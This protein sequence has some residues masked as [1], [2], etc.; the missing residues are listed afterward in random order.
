MPAYLLIGPSGVGKSSALRSVEARSKIPVYSLDEFIKGQSGSDSISSHL[1]IVGPKS[2][3]EESIQG[4]EYIESLYNQN[5]IIDVGAGSIDFGPGHEW[6]LSRNTICL[7]GDPQIIYERGGRKEHHLTIKE[8]IASEFSS[9]RS[10]LYEK[11]KFKIDVSYLNPE[12]VGLKI[13][14]LVKSSPMDS[15]VIRL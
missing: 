2:F 4:I 6:Y 14:E 13:I 7:I 9:A 10:R 8:F 3:F 12:A 5:I 11:A 15:K 1:R